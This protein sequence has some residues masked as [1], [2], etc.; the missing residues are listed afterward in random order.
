MG[1]HRKWSF[2]LVVDEDAS[3]R[4][5]IADY[6]T[7]HSFVAQ[8]TSGQHG[9]ACHLRGTEPDLVVLGVAQQHHDELDPLIE[10]RS[11]SNVP[12]IVTSRHERGELGAVAALELGAGDYLP[13]AANRM[14]F[15]HFGLAVSVAGFSASAFDVEAIDTV[16]AGSV[17]QIAGYELRFAGVARM[18]GPNYTADQ[19]SVEIRRDGALVALVHP[20]RRFFPLQQQTTAMTAIRTNFLSDL[21][22]EEAGN[23]TLRVYWKSPVPWIWIGAMFMAFGGMVSLSDRR[24]RVGVGAR[25][26][27]MAPT[28]QPAAG[29]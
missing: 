20:E 8:T 4:G 13:R 21:Y 16:H 18:P 9:M 7:D 26:R 3:M 23:W 14:S 2:A 10:I 6:L 1:E 27:R 15:A 28:L 5:A 25:A 12:I 24:W 19:A 29:E 22:G 11:R 17:V